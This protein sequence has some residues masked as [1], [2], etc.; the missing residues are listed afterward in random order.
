MV[1]TIR[2]PFP[3]E[4]QGR[5]ICP[6]SPAEALIL[7]CTKLIARVLIDHEWTTLRM[8]E[9]HSPVLLLVH[10]LR[11]GFDEE[12]VADVVVWAAS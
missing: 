1:T 5:N 9:G 12:G 7:V 8:S 11:F 4:Y 2:L 3:T 10:F 6:Q